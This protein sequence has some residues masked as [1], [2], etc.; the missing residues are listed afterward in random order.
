MIGLDTNVVI[1]YITQDDP[2][3]SAEAEKF[4]EQNCTV[5]EPGYINY[6]V[7]CEMVWVLKGAYGY[8]KN[9]IIGVLENL[10]QTAEIMVENSEVVWMALEAFK[11]GPADFSDY[12]IACFNK[13]AG[14]HYTATFDQ[15]A[16]EFN[17]FRK[18][19]V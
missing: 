6:M 16:G 19:K 12:L 8:D 1:R 15:D 18:L 11:T 10:I 17:L 7:L 3:Q 4:I 5:E 14:C 9:I 2:Q 13:Q